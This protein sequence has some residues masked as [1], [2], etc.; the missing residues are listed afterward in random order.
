MLDLK[1]LPR[2][3]FDRWTKESA[4]QKEFG[5]REILKDLI[6]PAKSDFQLNTSAFRKEA[7]WLLKRL[8][9]DRSRYNPRLRRVLYHRLL[10]R[11]QS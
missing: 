10:E 5:I 2:T 6:E 3:I 4:H 11:C 7:Q 8:R 9:C 1:H